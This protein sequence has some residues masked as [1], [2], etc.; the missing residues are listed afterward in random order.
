MKTIKELEE[1]T[2][3]SFIERAEL[4]QLKDI[5]KL[6]DKYIKRGDMG[7]HDLKARIKG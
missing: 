2:I 7:L 1:D 4:K 3:P 6:I 5:L